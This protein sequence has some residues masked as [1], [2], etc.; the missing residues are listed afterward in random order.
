MTPTREGLRAT[1]EHQIEHRSRGDAETYGSPNACWLSS[2]HTLLKSM[3]GPHT[4]KK[5]AYVA[6]TSRLIEVVEPAI[7]TPYTHLG[8]R[9]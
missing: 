9:E 3:Y 5:H 7:H 4:K 1:K 6:H 2:L 8:E